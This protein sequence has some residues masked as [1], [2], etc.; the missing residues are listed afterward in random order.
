M[1][2]V[3]S[4]TGGYDELRYPS[5]IVFKKKAT[6][7]VCFYASAKKVDG[8]DCLDVVNNIEDVYY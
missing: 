1:P 8:V 5:G 7:R 4:I 3:I 6:Y 2:I